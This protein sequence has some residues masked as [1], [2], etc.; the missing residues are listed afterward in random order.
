MKPKF[1]SLNALLFSCCLLILSGFYADAAQGQSAGMT[2]DV[3]KGI[4]LRSIG[5]AMSGGRVADIAIDPHKPSVYYVATG[6]GGLWKTDNRGNTFTPVF[7][8][9]G[10]FSLACVVIDPKNSDIVW[11]GTG[12]NSNPR[13]A[14]FGDGVYKSTDAGKNWI[15]V[16]LEKSEHI[17]NIKIDPRNSD[18]VYVAAQGPL[19]S[20]GGERGVYKTT[21]GGKTWKAVLTVSPDTGANE[22]IID[23]NNPDVLYASAWQ[24][25]RSVGQFIGGGPESAIYKSTDAGATWTKL[26]NG[27]P[28]GDM[29]RVGMA[30]D[31]GAKPTRVYALCNA[32]RDESGFYRSDDS[33]ET[34]ARVGHTVGGRRG[35]GPSGQAAGDDWYRGGDP[36]Y[37]S[38]LFIDPGLPNTIWSANTYLDRSTDGG[39]TWSVFRTEGFV[40]HVDYHAM[41][42][43]PT[44]VDHIIVGNDGG[45]Y[46]TYDHGARWRYFTNLP[47]TQFYRVA[48]DNAKPFYRVMGGTQDNGSWCGPSRTLKP[49]GILNT[50]WF[51]IGGGD[52]FQARSDPE[53]PN[54]VYEAEGRRVSRL[55]LRMGTSQPASPSGGGPGGTVAGDERPGWDVPY[56]ISPHSPRRLY[57]ASNFLYRSDNRG[58]TWTRISP[59][60]SRN[61][62]RNTI[63]IMGKVWPLDSVSLHAAT[64]AL[65]IIVSLDESPVF[66]G[67]IYVGT[68]DGL[69]QVTED[70]GKSWRKIE[71]F[72]G[73]PQWTYVSDVFASP[74]D[75]N[76]VFVALNNWQHGDFTPYLVK[77][78]DRGRTWTNIAG[79]L[80]AR[81]SVWSVIQDHLNGNLL[82]AGTEF[83]LFVTVDGGSHWV[84]LKGGLPVCQV[85]DLAV[86]RRENDL[87]LGTLGRAFY[88]LD[89]YSP[90]REITPAALAEEARLFPLRDA[91]LYNLTG[92]H[93]SDQGPGPTEGN[94]STPNP[95]LGAVFTYSVRQ[96]LPDDV[97][98]VL[99]IQDESG[100]QIRQLDLE[101]SGLRRVAWDLRGE[102]P[103]ATASNIQGAGGLG[104]GGARQ[105]TLVQPGLYRAV[106][107]KIVGDAITPIGQAQTFLVVRIP[108]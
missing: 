50:D 4:E 91:Y 53:D 29:G 92:V 18:V 66:E 56:I 71:K 60:L 87:V 57:Y 102:A 65:S 107:G 2:A 10:S 64:T 6:A 16:G 82:F 104:Q 8:K 32:K 38:E 96:D 24:R 54:I 93:P 51:R 36:G 105:G 30:V 21:D 80:P 72:P 37:Y 79:D 44:D 89:D 95:P 58:M 69:V 61:L 26:I 1:F 86:Q 106:L 63:P 59:D 17:G 85:R 13:A 49:W 39:K 77:S 90:L 74:R 73:V 83:G 20:S 25:R 62:N 76:T 14:M 103:P 33:G 27:L 11:L 97:K 23:P 47:V 35:G 99:A 15:R 108:Q 5:P 100:K 94:H 81:H 75:V 88:V 28:K 19:W 3:L 55:D 67:L 98:F 84:Q 34:W 68:D 7:D 41:A 43:D 70:G 78:T 40:M 48:V 12:E 9:G 31:A 46:E 45:L 42:W 101:K 22:V 52:G